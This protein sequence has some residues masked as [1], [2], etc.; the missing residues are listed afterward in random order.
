MNDI[1]VIGSLNADFLCLVHRLP[2]PGETVHCYDFL[3]MLGG[4]GGNQAAA[5]R[6]D[7][8]PGRQ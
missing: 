5:A 4:K 7:G 1:V 2:R 8:W 3:P 6:G